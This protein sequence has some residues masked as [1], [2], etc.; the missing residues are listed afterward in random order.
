MEPQYRFE[1]IVQLLYDISPPE[2]IVNQ[3]VVQDPACIESVELTVTL[4]DPEVDHLA[5]ACQL[6]HLKQRYSLPV[7]IS[8]K[9][10]RSQEL[11]DYTW[12]S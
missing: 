2:I 4:N 5:F 8:G 10:Q 6:M 3:P 1:L 9:I 7:L 12:N 11:K